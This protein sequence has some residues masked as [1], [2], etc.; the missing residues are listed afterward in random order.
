MLINYDESALQRPEDPMIMKNFNTGLLA[1][2]ALELENASFFSLIEIAFNAL[3]GL[4]KTLEDYEHITRKL[5]EYAINLRSRMIEYQAPQSGAG[6]GKPNDMVFVNYQMTVWSSPGIDLN[7]FFY[8][9]LPLDMLS[10]DTGYSL[11]T[12]DMVIT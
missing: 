10:N 7:Y 2:D 12:I 8:T 5:E 11:L 9:S 3:F 1:K 4:T 6:Q